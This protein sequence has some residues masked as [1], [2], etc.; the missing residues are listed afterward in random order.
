MNH[1]E[2]MA[3]LKENDPITYY[4][5]NSDPTNSDSD[6]SIDWLGFVVTG[7]IIISLTLYFT[8]NW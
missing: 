7:I 8:I 3:F 5:L 4:E 2:Q 1:K 6:T